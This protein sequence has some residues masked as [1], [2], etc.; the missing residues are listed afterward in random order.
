MA[1]LHYESC[2]NSSMSSR[3]TAHGPRPSSIFASTATLNKF[4]FLLIKTFLFLTCPRTYRMF[5]PTLDGPSAIISSKFFVATLLDDMFTLFVSFPDLRHY[6]APVVHPRSLSAPSHSCQFVSF[7]YWILTFWAIV[8]LQS[9]YVNSSH[10]T[11]L[12]PRLSRYRVI[13]RAWVIILLRT[14][15]VTPFLAQHF[16]PQPRGTVIIWLRTPIVTLFLT[17]AFCNNPVMSAI[18]DLRSSFAVSLWRR[19]RNK[20][21]APHHPEFPSSFVTTVERWWNGPVDPR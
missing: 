8:W 13:S 19:R 11:A 17:R 5:I 2:T 21:R 18:R 6:E 14:P 4:F 12:T 16:N 10:Y 7:W 20:L 3:H 9:W 1:W 15:I